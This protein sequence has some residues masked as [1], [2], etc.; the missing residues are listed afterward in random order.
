MIHFSKLELRISRA[1]PVVFQVNRSF[2][3][4]PPPRESG[5]VFYFCGTPNPVQVLVIVYMAAKRSYVQST[6]KGHLHY[7]KAV[8]F[9]ECTML[10][11]HFGTTSL[12]NLN[13]A[14]RKGGIHG[15][16]NRGY[17][18]SSQGVTT[19]P[20]YTQHWSVPVDHSPMEWHLRELRGAKVGN[21]PIRSCL[22][23]GGFHGHGGS[24]ARWM[25]FLSWKIPSR[26]GND[27][28]GYLYFWDTIFLIAIDTM[29]P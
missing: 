17:G 16:T 2:P 1:F 27:S 4:D 9:P 7:S 18:S 11:N 20:S 29:V 24:P 8:G 14:G 13:R 3:K 26:N 12:Q 19:I 25:V 15:Q 22:R 28:W 23:D 5:I 21:V 10:V 6:F